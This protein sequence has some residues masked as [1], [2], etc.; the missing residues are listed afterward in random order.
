[1]PSVSPSSPEASRRMA[2]VRQRGTDVEIELRRAL[3]ALGLRYRLQVP[4]SRKPRRVADIVFIGARVAVFVDGCF[5]H[6]CPL[7]ATWPKENA[8]FWRAKIEA[9][10]ARDADTTRRLRELGWEVIRV[11]SHEDPVEAARL[12]YDRVLERKG[13]AS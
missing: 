3:H 12:I 7:H 4:L 2:R 10:R 1:M 6:G 11:W 13:R 5:W 9:N 8:G